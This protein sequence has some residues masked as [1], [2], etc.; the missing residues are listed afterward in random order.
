MMKPLLSICIVAGL[1]GCRTT[2]SDSEVKFYGSD[3]QSAEMSYKSYVEVKLP[4]GITTDTALM[5]EPYK[6]KMTAL[7][8]RQ[9]QHMFG[10]FTEHPEYRRNPGIIQ[11]KGRPVILSAEVNLAG[12]TAKINY[13]Y[14]D[15]VV[16]K[17][18]VMR[19]GVT[20][21]KFVLPK[22]PVTIY[23]KGFPPG[24]SENKCTDEHYNSEGDFWYFWNPKKARC[25]IQ[26]ADLVEIEADIIPI[27]NTKKTFPYYSTLLGDNGNG[28]KLSIVY[29]V[30]IDEGFNSGDLGRETYEEAIK[31]LVLKGFTEKSGGTALKKTMTFSKPDYE[32][33]L[34]ISLADPDSA[35]FIADAAAGLENADVF[36]YDG[37]SGL[38]GYLNLERFQTTLGRNL[39]L[40]VDKNQIFYFNGCSTFAYY[41]ADYFGLKKT[42]VDPEGRKNLDIIT[43]SIGAS[44][45]I[46][47]RHDIE[48]IVGLTDGS[49]P[50]WQVMMDRIYRVD[51]YQTALTH[52]NGD[53]DN[54]TAAK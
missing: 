17:K 21:I 18:K 19:N 24:G 2:D 49:R 22:D 8:D 53:E 38:G 48:L 33:E 15:T 13:S 14:T 42:A 50:S 43:T 27:A 32:V 34:L 47:A 46:G 10:T 9:I 31:L 40:P 29:L 54:P 52:V 3:N 6:T 1:F 20:K 7:V 5:A 36:I 45:D 25:P 44:F 51:R 23:S 26:P 16:F 30:G 4:A 41:N 39:K 12:K 35:A 28:K 37:H 11:S